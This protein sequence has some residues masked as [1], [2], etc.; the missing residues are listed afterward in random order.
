M[1][2]NLSLRKIILIPIALFILTAFCSVIMPVAE[3]AAQDAPL[4]HWG[5]SGYR[6]TKIQQRLNWWG[7]YEGPVDGLFG[8]KTSKAVRKFQ[9]YNGLSKDGV[10]GRQTLTALG[11]QEFNRTANATTTTVSRSSAY[12]NDGRVGL[13]AKVI[14]GEAADEPFVGKVAVGAVML[15]RTRSSAFPQSLSSVIYQPNAF[16]SVTNGMYNRTTSEESIKA[17]RLALN[18]WDPTGG[19]LF[20]WNPAKRV[21]SWI[22]SRPIITQIGGHVFAR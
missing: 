5:S 1:E 11:L 12:S 17:A 4:L 16:E 2:I 19:A 7:Y 10:V 13:L 8:T 3:A 14:E 20:F 6:V 22:W 21:S 18:G 15:N 9:G